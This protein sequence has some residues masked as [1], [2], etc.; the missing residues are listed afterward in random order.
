MI[1]KLSIIITVL[2]LVAIMCLS[3][4]NFKNNN[5][6]VMNPNEKLN[7]SIKTS[8]TKNDIIDFNKLTNFEWDRMYVITPYGNPEEFLKKND[9][10]WIQIDTS[11]TMLDDINLIVFTNSG[12]I[13]NYVNF[14]RKYGDFS[15]SRSRAFGK[16][17]AI[18][19]V[20]KKNGWV[21]LIHK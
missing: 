5:K 17:D 2:I 21:Y 9:V 16:N 8:I 4:F 7:E 11:I 20:V 10:K 12:R 1:K 13:I 15:I 14:K 6:V 3:F 19:G 18:F